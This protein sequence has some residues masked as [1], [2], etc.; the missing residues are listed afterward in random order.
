MSRRSP[1][2]L[3]CGAWG[4]GPTCKVD[5]PIQRSLVAV[6]SLEVTRLMNLLGMPGLGSSL[7]NDLQRIHQMRIAILTLMQVLDP[8][9]VEYQRL[10]DCIAESSSRVEEHHHGVDYGEDFD[11]DNNNVDAE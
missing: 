3:R 7:Q 10:V 8:L 1:G 11:F 9:E 5:L 4:L 6:A 2:Q